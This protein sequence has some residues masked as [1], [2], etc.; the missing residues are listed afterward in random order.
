MVELRPFERCDFARLI[1]WMNTPRFLLQWAGPAITFP[2]DGAQFER[3]LPASEGPQPP[4]KIFKAVDGGTGAV[5]GH[6]EP[7]QIDLHN[8]SATV[9]RV[10]VGESAAPGKRLG[11][12]MVRRVLDVGFGELGL[13]RISL[14]VFDFNAPAIA[15]YENVGFAIEG[16][17]RDTRRF[18]HEYW[19]E[20]QMSI[21]ES[22][23]RSPRA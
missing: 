18:D 11:A 17:L 23:W 2:L 10:L 12:Q 9:S 22:E 3:H 14:I 13:H 1:G 20:V 6:I 7:G 15:C 4:R 5:V 16:R 19:N 8:R 21:L